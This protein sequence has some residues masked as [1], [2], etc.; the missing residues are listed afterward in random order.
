MEWDGTGNIDRDFFPE[1]DRDN[2]IKILASKFETE[3]QEMAE[4][5]ENCMT[6]DSQ[7]KPTQDVDV[8]NYKVIN[9]EDGTATADAINF[10]QLD[11]VDTKVDANTA[12][13]TN[14]G[15]AKGYIYGGL[16]SNNAVTP[17]DIIDISAVKT[18]SSDDT[19]NIVVAAGTLDITDNTSWASGSAPSLTDLSVFVWAVYDE[20]TPYYILDNVTGSN[21]TDEKRLVGSFITDSADDI[22]VFEAVEKAGGGVAFRMADIVISSGLPSSYAAIDIPTPINSYPHYVVYTDNVVGNQDNTLTYMRSSS[23]EHYVTGTDGDA[24]PFRDQAFATFADVYNSTGDIEFK[25]A[26]TDVKVLI[27]GYT[28]ERI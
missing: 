4:T 12:L 8:N 5:Y 6:L 7:T 10:G 25:A 16:L 9:V 23:I 27:R 18:R 3:F 14:L 19:Q 20:T 2:D 15:Y 17:D 11:A 21:I 24:S 26:T 1:E 13:I 22:L 28:I